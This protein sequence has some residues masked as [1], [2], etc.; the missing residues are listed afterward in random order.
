VFAKGLNPIRRKAGINCGIARML[1]I[2]LIATTFSFAAISVFAQTRKEEPLIKQELKEKPPKEPLKE[3][4]VKGDSDRI[5]ASFTPGSSY[6]YYNSPTLVDDNIYV[7]T[8]RKAKDN[9]VDDNYF[10]KLDTD[11]NKIWEYPL[12]LSEVRGGATLDSE[13]NIYFV[14]EEGKLKIED[15]DYNETYSQ[16]SLSLTVFHYFKTRAPVRRVLNPENV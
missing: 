15:G 7:G 8:S 2:L 12:Y 14:V 9:P 6:F 13:G 16:V 1:S 3:S 10:F 4:V 5:I 11:L